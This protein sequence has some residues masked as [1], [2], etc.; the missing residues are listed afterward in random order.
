VVI[1]AVLVKDLGDEGK[2]KCSVVMCAG[3]VQGGRRRRE[4]ETFQL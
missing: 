4:M 2:L 1:F 3:L